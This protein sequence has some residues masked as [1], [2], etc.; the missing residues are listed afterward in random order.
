MTR[1]WKSS[2][3]QKFTSSY[4]LLYNHLKHQGHIESQTRF[5]AMRDASLAEWRELIAV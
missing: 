4:A 5:K 3:L 1:V 2:T